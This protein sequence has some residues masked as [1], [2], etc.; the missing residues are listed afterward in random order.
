MMNMPTM[1]IHVV[2]NPSQIMEQGR[3]THY[4][5]IGLLAPGDKMRQLIHPIDMLPTVR[6]VIATREARP[7][8]VI[9]MRQYLRVNE[10][11]PHG[12]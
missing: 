2:P 11:G 5:A 3:H 7:Y 10:S 1:L 4:K 12:T 8:L 6:Q 9:R